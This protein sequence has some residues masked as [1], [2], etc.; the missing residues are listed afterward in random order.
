M[1]AVKLLLFLLLLGGGGYLLFNELFGPF[2]IEGIEKELQ[3]LEQ[4]HH[5]YLQGFAE[6]ERAAYSATT[7]SSRTN[8]LHSSL[9]REKADRIYRYEWKRSRLLMRL[10]TLRSK[11]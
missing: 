1:N 11:Q 10:A 5:K 6:R 9:A 2:T 8:R 4:Q 7:D 3:R